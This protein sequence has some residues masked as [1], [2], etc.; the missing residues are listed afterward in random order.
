MDDSESRLVKQKT[1]A[2]YQETLRLNEFRLLQ[3]LPGSDDVGY[4]VLQ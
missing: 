1:A 3:L 4:I 2:I